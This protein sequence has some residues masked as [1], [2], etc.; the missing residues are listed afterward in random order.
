MGDDEPEENDIPDEPAEPVRVQ[1]VLP[2]APVAAT[3][4]VPGG[5]TLSAAGLAL[6]T[7]LVLHAA[8]VIVRRLVGDD[9]AELLELAFNR[10]GVWHHHEVSREQL[11]TNQRIIGLARIGLPITTVNARA[12][13]TYLAEFE[14]DN[15]DCIPT[16]RL[17]RRTGWHTIDGRDVFVLPNRVITARDTST[18]IASPPAAIR[19]RASGDGPAQVADGLCTGGHLVGWL[20]IMILTRPFPRA[21]FAFYV[22]L[23]PALLKILDAPN[24]VLDFS[25]STS[26]GKT[27]VLRI[28]AAVWGCPDESAHNSLMVTWDT[29]AAYRHDIAAALV[30]IPLVID[31][32]RL[33]DSPDEVIQ[34]VYSVANGRTRGRQ[35]DTT[36]GLSTVLIT[37]GEVPIVSL[38]KKGG[39]RARC[40][41]LW[42]SPFVNTTPETA[43]VVR[44][45]NRGLMTHYGFAGRIFVQYL[46]DHHD[47]WDNWREDY[48]RRVEAY[49]Q[50]AN[51]D[52]VISRMAAALAAIS[53]ATP[54]AHDALELPWENEDV[55]AVLWDE[56]TAEGPD[57]DSAGAALEH[58]IDWARGHQNQFFGEGRPRSAQSRGG[59]AGRWD[60]GGAWI[61]FRPEILR[62]V[63]T[64]GGFEFDAMLRSW[65]ERGW[66]LVDASSG[67]ARHRARI[68]QENHWLIAIRMEAVRQ[69][70]GAEADE[71]G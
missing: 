30:N 2:T 13:L 45:L 6:G 41:S 65:R 18:G 1:D 62:R 28:V 55:V 25:G 43:S 20:E 10:N 67:K 21:R 32:T 63:L 9:G 37:T 36:A 26:R 52:P 12:I 58:A 56:L 68:G 40:F 64:E 50:R 14:R 24:F 57:A 54:L 17:T 38:S 61:G 8:L 48:R 47:L 29:T 22:A 66:V 71:D 70:E 59:Y 49:E 33:A 60:D 51:G 5:W 4:V 46:V 44:R 11:T 35:N 39:A 27:T 15:H 7:A 34:T 3:S 19:F 42:G 16:V 53:M 31:E 23:V 69:V